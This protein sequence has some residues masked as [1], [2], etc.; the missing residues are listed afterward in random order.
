MNAGQRLIVFCV[1]FLTLSMGASFTADAQSFQYQLT[2]VPTGYRMAGL[3]SE[4]V[5]DLTALPGGAELV[6]S[7]A[8]D[9]TESSCATAIARS[10]AT[11]KL[12]RLLGDASRAQGV[13]GECYPSSG[14]G[15]EDCSVFLQ[16]C[17]ETGGGAGSLPGG[18]YS[19]S[20]R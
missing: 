18:G 19:C 5:T 3:P 10:E 7:K 20:N 9:G 14:E 4:L 13:Y 2:K 12:L 15:G 17:D 11:V 8:R 16:I 6:T 1:A